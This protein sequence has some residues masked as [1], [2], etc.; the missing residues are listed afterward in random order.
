[1]YTLWITRIIESTYPRFKLHLNDRLI[2]FMMSL[3]WTLNAK[4]YVKYAW[5]TAELRPQGVKYAW[6]TAELRPQGVKYAWSTA[7]LRP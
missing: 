6:S 7:E 4:L 5:S 2:P 3:K 1:M